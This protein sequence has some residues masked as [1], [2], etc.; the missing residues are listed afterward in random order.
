MARGIHRLK[1]RYL[2]RLGPGKHS[3]GGNLYLL[4]K[5]GGAKSWLFIYTA[6]NGKRREI[7]L[8]PVN[9][10]SL[11]VARA[12]AA[13]LRKALHQGRDPQAEHDRLR[14]DAAPA[15][16]FKEAAEEYIASHRAGWKNAKHAQ[17]WANTLETYA[18]PTMGALPVSA[19]G[20]ADVLEVLKPIWATKPETAARVRGRIEVVLSFARVRGWRNGENPALWKGN[21]DHLLPARSKVRRVKHH[22]AMSYRDVPAFLTAL[23]A[24]P[25]VSPQALRFVILTVARTGEAIGARWP[26]ADTEAAVWTVPA[27][28]MKARREHRVPLNAPALEILG[29]LA[30]A[31]EYVFPGL[32]RGR[33]L[34][35]MA[36]LMTLRRMKVDDVTVHGFRSSFRDWAAEQTGFPREVIEAALAHANGDKVEAAYLRTDHFEKR[37][38]LMAAWGDFCTG[39]AAANVAQL[40]AA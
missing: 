7:G 23:A 22:A 20:I 38:L 30:R 12:L 13:G 15:K 9:G 17:Q 39:A 4:A 19:V 28:R 21:L 18:Y 32:K 10:V 36:L 8:G 40:K 27:E 6:A 5:H 29:E 16:T 35:Q 3:D 33:P 24:Q 2:E 1:A 37:R 14:V 31:G 25:G 11:D 34:S 26:E